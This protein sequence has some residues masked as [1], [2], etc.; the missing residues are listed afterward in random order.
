M[1]S[2]WQQPLNCSHPKIFN[3]QTLENTEGAIKKGQSGNIWY[4]KQAKTNKN[5][6]QYVMDTTMR[7][8]FGG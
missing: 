8:I 6:T 1:F 5:T 7:K 4:T 3:K 2:R